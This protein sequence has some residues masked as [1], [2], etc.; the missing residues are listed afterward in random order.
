MGG[1]D[2]IVPVLYCPPCAMDGFRGFV[3]NCKMLRITRMNCDWLR[4]C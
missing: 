1:T 4:F 2:R 3:G